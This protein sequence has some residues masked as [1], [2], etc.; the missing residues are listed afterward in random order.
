MDKQA[1][2]NQQLG[3]LL[4]KVVFLIDRTADRAL[5]K[6]VGISLSQ[7]LVLLSVDK[8][9][10]LVLSQQAIA[11]HLGIHKAAVSRHVDALVKKYWLVRDQHPKSHREYQLRLTNEGERILRQAQ[12]IMRETMSKH[13]LA[14]GQ[15]KAEV[16]LGVLKSI[17]ASLSGK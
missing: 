16:V 9:S 4:H 13:Y 17:Y 14:A 7:F 8:Q 1:H 3:H 12:G 2:L 11:N 5:Q 6:E 10:G 15:Q